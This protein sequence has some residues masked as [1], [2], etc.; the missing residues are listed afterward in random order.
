MAILNVTEYQGPFVN[1]ANGMPMARAPKVAQN[2]QAITAGSTQSAA[3]NAAT[4]MIRVETDVI[5]CIE[6]GANPTAIVLGLTMTQ[7]MVAGQTEYFYVTK[8]AGHKIAVIAS[9]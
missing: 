1:Q 2:N 9:T 7:R 3:F 6:I 4:T 8:G 5:C